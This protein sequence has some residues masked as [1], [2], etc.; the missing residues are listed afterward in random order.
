MTDC[1]PYRSIETGSSKS[2]LEATSSGFTSPGVRILIF[3][4]WRRYVIIKSKLWKVNTK[5]KSM[6]ACHLSRL[7]QFLYGH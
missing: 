3:L 7:L 2:R 6:L 1:S 4:P 5:N